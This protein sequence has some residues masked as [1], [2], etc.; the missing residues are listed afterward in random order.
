MYM[1]SAFFFFF[2]V[3]LCFCRRWVYNWTHGLT[4]LILGQVAACKRLYIMHILLRRA[5]NQSRLT[6]TKFNVDFSPLN[7]ETMFKMC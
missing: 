2:L 7:L 3:C 6:Q 4:G 5:E 1:L